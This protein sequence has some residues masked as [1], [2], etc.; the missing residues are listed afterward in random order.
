M[1]NIK[2]G[3]IYWIDAEPHSGR[4]EGGHSSQHHN[5][6]RPVVVVSND[7]YNRQEMAIVFPITS[8]IKRSRYLLPI[9]LRKQSNIILTQILGYD[10]KARNAENSG[11][12]V[13]KDELEFLKQ[14]VA[15]ML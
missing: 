4:E 2:Q 9:M 12:S 8:K 3:E 14:I 10:M 15:H 7:H 1:L 6:R 5:I 11:Y 13:T